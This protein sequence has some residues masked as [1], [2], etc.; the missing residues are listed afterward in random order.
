MAIVCSAAEFVLPS[1]ALTTIIPCSV[2]AVKSMLSTP[3][4][5]RPIN[6][7][8]FAASIISRVTVV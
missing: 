5:A 3:T 7:K 2:A 1:G 8:F 4:P 6:F